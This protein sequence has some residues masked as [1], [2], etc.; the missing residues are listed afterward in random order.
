MTCVEDGWV[1]NPSTKPEAK[2]AK[3][4]SNFKTN[5]IYSRFD[6]KKGRWIDNEVE[7]F[8]QEETYDTRHSII[9]K[10]I[11]SEDN[12][13]LNKRQIIIR[14]PGLKSLLRDILSLYLK[15]EFKSIFEKEKIVLTEPFIALNYNWKQ[16]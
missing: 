15:H 5:F 11:F 13:K 1:D 8:S 12:T 10:R 16:L 2:L 4:R 14:S 3:G 7:G 6:S 9:A